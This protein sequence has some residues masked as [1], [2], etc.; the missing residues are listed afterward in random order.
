MAL[1]NLYL[2]VTMNQMCWY[3]MARAGDRN[4]I[5]RTPLLRFLFVRVV[6]RRSCVVAFRGA[7]LHLTYGEKVPIA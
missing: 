5:R 1:G 6:F 7:A 4:D 3:A 2:A